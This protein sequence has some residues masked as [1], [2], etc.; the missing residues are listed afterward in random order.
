MKHRRNQLQRIAALLATA[1]TSGALAQC[2]GY[3]LEPGPGALPVP[4]TALTVWDPDGPGPA[5]PAPVV[6]VGSSVMRWDGHVWQAVGSVGHAVGGMAV[7]NGELLVG[8][9]MI[10]NE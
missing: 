3:V 1:G 9:S 5:E 10:G 4:V 8:T 2:G 7:F 6:G